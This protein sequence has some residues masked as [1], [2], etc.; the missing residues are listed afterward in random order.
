MLER[1]SVEKGYQGYID[2]ERQK[3]HI[4][5]HTYWRDMA[6]RLNQENI[7][8]R[9]EAMDRERS[10]KLHAIW[11]TVGASLLLIALFLHG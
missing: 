6:V 10:A 1:S 4:E 9:L 5:R 2:Y 3:Y 11:V 8:L 7:D